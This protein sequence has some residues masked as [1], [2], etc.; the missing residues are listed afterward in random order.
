MK[1]V[2]SILVLN[3]FTHDNRVFKENIS[4]L[5]KGYKTV[6]VAKYD[7]NL[8]QHE[9]ISGIEVFR[10]KL[11]TK[12]WPKN[13]FFKIIK[14]LE[15]IIKF[16]FLFND[17]D[18]YH[19]ND[20]EAFPLG[21]LVKFLFNRQAKIVYDA[22]EYEIEISVFNKYK[23]L[24]LH[25]LEGALIKHADLVLTVSNS[26]ACEY[27]RLYKINKPKLVLNCPKYEPIKK[28]YLLREELG[29]RNDQKIFLYQ[30][31]LSAVRGLEKLLACFSKMNDDKNVVV[32]MG[33]GP[34]EEEIKSWKSRNVFFHKAV[35]PRD[36]P[37][38]TS[39]A[40]YG[41]F[42]CD[43]ICKNFY[44]CLPNKLFEYLHAGLPVIVSD[45]YELSDFVERYKV[46]LV[47]RDT[48]IDT[49]QKV[50]DEILL[51][52]YNEL[53]K[54]ALEISKRFCWENQ[55]KVLITEYANLYKNGFSK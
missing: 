26:I 20:L 12:N 17:A 44:Y 24:L 40:D 41:V 28:F 2:I 38:Y 11:L 8:P 43:N 34:M 42:I 50:I 7:K 15:F 46:G 31:A 39:S 22:H 21:F 32:F 27:K 29:I 14:Y 25:F 16:L 30:G 52:N 51:L 6:V 45:L 36:L 54:N 9:Y 53:S 19:C 1:K 35:T 49:I 10:L 18:I 5:N 13:V 33:Y 3:S 37:A 55:E 23:R 47:C 48:S 4:L